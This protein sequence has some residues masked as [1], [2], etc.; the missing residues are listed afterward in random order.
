MA[1]LL[2][3]K[4]LD[5]RYQRDVAIVS[6]LSFSVDAGGA[7]IFRGPNGSGKTTALLGLLGATPFS[8]GEVLID[9]RPLGPLPWHRIGPGRLGVALQREPVFPDLTGQ[10]HVELACQLGAVRPVARRDMMDLPLFEPLR[11]PTLLERRAGSYSGGE[12]RLLSIA[13]AVLRSPRALLLDEPTA[14]LQPTLLPLLLEL[15]ERLRSTGVAVLVVEHLAALPIP[16][17]AVIRF[18]VGGE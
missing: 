9:A 16:G 11:K 10:Q 17:A 14:G 18:P 6:R 1:A 12:Q 13:C 15:L 4:G 5:P 8:S 3:V 2:E 7:L